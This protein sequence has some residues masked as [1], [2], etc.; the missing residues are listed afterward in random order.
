MA[1][2]K[3]R[4]LIAEDSPT[5]RNLLERILQSDEQ[6][7][8]IGTAANG[9]QAVEKA[10]ELK[11]DIVTMDIRMP[12]M[13]GFQATKEIMRRAPTPILVI[14]A[15]V[16]S[17]DLKIT[18]NAIQAGAL[19]I[20]EKPAGGL[21]RSNYEKM[22]DKIIRKVKI[23]SEIKVF[24]HVSGRKHGVKSIP[25]RPTEHTTAP[26]KLDNYT[27]QIIG[28]AA[29]TGGPGTLVKLLKKLPADFPI[30]IVIVQ[31]I[32]KGFGDGFIS[33][34]GNEVKLPVFAA[35]ADAQILQ[36]HIYVA[37]DD[38]HLMVNGGKFRLTKSLPVSGLRPYATYLF[39][40]LA[41]NY[42]NKAMGIVLTGMG[43]DGSEG[44][45]E[46]REKGGLTVA[47]DESTS[48]VFGMPREAI[49][50]GAAKFILTPDETAQMMMRISRSGYGK[51]K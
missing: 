35:K 2:S 39:R 42:G 45:L 11:P 38:Y 20:I 1:N 17:D 4:V 47:Q 34:L 3:I 26:Q 23:I 27:V 30:P 16:N 46:M 28:I 14:S 21:L 31:H 22:A 24:H 49:E 13:D 33:W 5:I 15:S 51:N 6:I 25:V 40:S 12:V 10:I 29:S 43:R 44:L 9:K 32:T 37:P 41:E 48:V 50:L 18:F 36:K 19:D 7:E 8:V